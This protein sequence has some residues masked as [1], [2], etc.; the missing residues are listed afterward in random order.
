M[1]D[2]LLIYSSDQIKSCVERVT[3]IGLNETQVH[4]DIEVTAYYAGHLLGACMF[5][6][7]YKEFSVVYTGDYNSLSD[8]HLGAAFIDKLRPDVL[9]SES[10]YATIVRDSKRTRERKFLV[11]I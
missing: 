7:R 1:K 9:I 11:K 3:V 10:T 2:P 6:I 4:N 8:R 5:H